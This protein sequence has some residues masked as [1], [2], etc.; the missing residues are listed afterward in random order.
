[1]SGTVVLVDGTAVLYRQFY[2]LGALRNSRGEPTQAVFGLMRVLE[3]LL[4]EH[5]DARFAVVLD[6]GGP[7]FRHEAFADYKAQRSAMPDDLVRQIPDAVALVEAL[8]WPLFR[9]PGV[10]A[11]DV[12]ATLATRAAE[13]GEEVLVVT[14]D[15]DLAQLVGGPVALLD[16][17]RHERI[18][19]EE[20]RARYGVDPERIVDY[21]A[22]VGDSSDNIPGLRGVGAKTAARWLATYGSLEGVLSHAGEL[23]PRFAPLLAEEAERLRRNTELIR[24][25]RDVPLPPGA[26]ALVSRPAD[27]E[28]LAALGERLGI[29]VGLLGEARRT[30]ADAAGTDE[31]PAA[32]RAPVVHTLRTREELERWIAR[33]RA[34]PL[35]ALDTETTSLDYLE[36]RLVGLALAAHP[37]EAC[38]VPLAHE[39]GESPEFTREEALAL[40]RPLVEGE[41][42]A[43]IGH[44]TKY[45]R[46]VLAN[47]GLAF[48]GVRDDTML[49]SY[50]LDATD[51]PHSLDAIARRL[52]DAQTTSYDALTRTPSGRRPFAAVPLAQAAAYAGED[53][54]LTLRVHEVLGPRL[55][56]DPAAE[57]LYRTLEMPLAEVLYAMER[58][59]VLVDTTLLA[60]QNEELGRELETLRAR[61][62]EIAGTTFNPDSPSQVRDVLFGKLQLRPRRRTP[63][64]EASTSEEVLEE[65]A[66]EHE[67]P[68]VL[69]AYRALAKLRSTYTEQLPRAVRPETGRI[70]T[71][72]HQAAT[73]TGRLSSSHPNLQN[74]PIRSPE[75]RRIRRAFVAPEGS[76]L[77]SFDYS[78]IELRIMAHLS[79][80]EGLREA[81]RR[82]LDVHRA[83]AA[84]ILGRPPESVSDEERRSAKAVNFGLIYGMSPHGLARTLGVP[85]AEARAYIERYFGRY[86]RVR[87]FMDEIRLRAR[88]EGYVTTILG[89]R[90]PVRGIRD[91]SAVRRQAAE[92]A[93]INAPMQGSA[94]EIIKLAMIAT[95]RHLRER[96]PEAHLILQVHD[97]LVIEAP[98]DETPRLREEVRALMDGVLT[99]AVPLV[100]DVGEGPNWDEA[101]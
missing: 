20:V 98:A 74:I 48:G 50:V 26:D 97:E 24:L 82:G 14:N 27:R 34:S 65:L 12:L 2:A 71:Q 8:G 87:A 5:P 79:G 64:G 32:L 61:A 19:A 83:V 57:H 90:L 78:Q 15:K 86:P 25:K 38:Y 58:R 11:D 9:V 51:L 4:R 72:Y 63:G 28:R 37:G 52:F 75:G 76:R 42:P 49:E 41:R 29:R 70:H 84:E 7:T 22:L 44:H 16:P 77:L 1:M 40:L 23:G 45:D 30:A 68:A 69:L 36:A 96:Y 39:G 59:G 99:L 85:L 54:D 62:Q 33:F 93:A 31:P 80:D 17:A 95:H 13:R 47:H 10:E 18:G 35:L 91:R 81:F 46:H 67:L 66:S 101:H 92:R 60:V 55:A 53:V 21:L 3:R 56:A 43:K 88:E 89:R 6:A 100:V 94:A 73:A